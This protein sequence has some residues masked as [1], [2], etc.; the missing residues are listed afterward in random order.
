M[1]TN[2]DFDEAR[3]LTYSQFVSK[4]VYNKRN[5]S[6]QPRK[7]GYTIGRL[8]WVPP[9]TGELFY[10]RMMLDCCKGPTSFEDIRTIANIQYPTYREACFAM[11]F[12]QD[13]REY[14]EAIKEAKDWGTTNYLRKLFVLILL[15]GAMSKPEEVWNQ[16]WHWLADDIAYQYTKSTISSGRL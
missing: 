12:L 14:V 9:T 13:D 2:K 11:G 5:R 16:C 8:I 4:F 10:L 1:N 7:K 3:N 6:W 15:T